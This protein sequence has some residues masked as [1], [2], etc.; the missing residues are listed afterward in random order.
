LTAPAILL[1]ERLTHHRVHSYVLSVGGAVLSCLVLLRLAGL[2]RAVERAGRAERLARREAEQAQRLL[3]HQNEQ[4]REL[5]TLK[6][7]FVSSVSHELRTPLTSISGYLELMLEDE[8]DAQKRNY[9]GVIERNAERLLGLVSDLLFSARLQGGRLE[10]ERSEID[11]QRLV[12]QAVESARPR[13]EAAGVELTLAADGVPPI[14]GEAARLAQVLDNLVSNSIKFTPDGGLVT[15]RLSS[16]DGLVRFEISDTGIGIAEPERE[17][18]FER[19]FRSQSA[20]ERQIQGTGLGLYIS[21][22]I[23]EA[24]GGRIGVESVAGEGTTFVVELP[25]AE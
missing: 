20:L 22:A 25:A 10:L 13:A 19:F 18:L 14:S 9:L 5:D 15:V 12:V 21:K 8:Q 11:L 7:E 2:V 6:D 4:L 24:H 23:V 16:R 17:R 3:T 1:L